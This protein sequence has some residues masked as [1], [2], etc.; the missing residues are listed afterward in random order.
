M[1]KRKLLFA[2][3]AKPRGVFI[4]QTSILGFHVLFLCTFNRASEINN[5]KHPKQLVGGFNPSE[6]Y[7]R[8]IVH[9]FP[10]LRARI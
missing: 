10:K 2:K 7:A 5:Q 1:V 8:Q 9:Q 3:P 6:E 4:I